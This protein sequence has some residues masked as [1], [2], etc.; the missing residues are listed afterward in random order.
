MSEQWYCIRVEPGCELSV[1]E[2]L[3]LDRGREKRPE[4]KDYLAAEG[5]ELLVPIRCDR[6]KRL[7]KWVEIH[8]PAIQGYVFR[9]MVMTSEAYYE[10]AGTRETPGIRGVVSFL[11]KVNPHPITEA[12]I[13]LMKRACADTFGD[14]AE[15]QDLGW[16]LNKRFT[17][18]EGPFTSFPGQCIGFDGPGRVVMLV[19]IFGRTNPVP[20]DLSWVDLSGDAQYV[21]PRK[22]SAYIPG[23]SK[24]RG[25]ARSG[26]GR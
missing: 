6:I 23:I 1:A 8:N 24:R 18:A 22:K 5:C 12:E 16:M 20:M 7:G 10:I 25:S 21:A 19:E 15:A 17:I 9:H 14:S 13:K 26:A 4:L 2:A 11:P 3:R